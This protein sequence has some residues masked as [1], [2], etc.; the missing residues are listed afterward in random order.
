MIRNIEI[1]GSGIFNAFDPWVAFFR[2]GP[3][4]LVFFEKVEV[5]KNWIFKML[6]FVFDLEI[7]FIFLLPEYSRL[8]GTLVLREEDFVLKFSRVKFPA[9]ETSF[10]LLHF[11][12]S[13]F[14]E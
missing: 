13:P 6:T 4:S 1:L 12:V 11:N 8:P 2:K 9:S 7:F 3:Q 10:E 14:V 5:T